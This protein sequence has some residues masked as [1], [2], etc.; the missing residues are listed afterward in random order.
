MKS[1]KTLLNRLLHALIDEWGFKEVAA[2]LASAGTAPN[3]ALGAQSADPIIRTT[4]KRPKP[5]A[6][7]QTQQVPVEGEQKEALLHLAMRYE[8]KL[9]LPSV[10]DV[11]EFLIMMGEQPASMKDRKEAFRVLLRSLVRLPTDRLQH[12]AR[13]SLHSGPSEL[14]PLSDAIAGASERLPRQRDANTNQGT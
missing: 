3:Q 8:Q 12:L 10:A 6:I 4:Q 13:T 2:A 7:E 9:F 1:R 14:G 5:G 11:R